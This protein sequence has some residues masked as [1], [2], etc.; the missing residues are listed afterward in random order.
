M[1]RPSRLLSATLRYCATFTCRCTGCGIGCPPG[2][3][4]PIRGALLPA[5]AFVIATIVPAI[6]A[7]KAAIKL[8]KIAP[9]GKIALTPAAPAEMVPAAT[10]ACTAAVICAAMYAIRKSGRRYCGAARPAH[11]NSRRH[12]GRNGT[13]PLHLDAKVV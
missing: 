4:G 1:S 13:I 2:G 6:A 9:A 8:A 7:D 10:P 3:C 11:A 12:H 5:H